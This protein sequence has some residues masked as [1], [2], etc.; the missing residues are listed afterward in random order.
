MKWLYR[1]ETSVV[2]EGTTNQSE[3]CDRDV[4]HSGR[5]LLVG[6]EGGTWSEMEGERIT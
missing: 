3:P 4:I 6:T 5:D 2:G 1:P